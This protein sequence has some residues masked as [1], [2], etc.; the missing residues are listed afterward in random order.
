MGTEMEQTD[1]GQS[2]EPGSDTKSF[3]TKEELNAFREEILRETK[4]SLSKSFQAVQ[5]MTDKNANRLEQLIDEKVNGIVE[6]LRK[7]GKEPT[8]QEVQQIR[9]EAT[10][11]TLISQQQG[12]GGNAEPPKND[13]D[14]AGGDTA[15]EEDLVVQEAAQILKQYGLTIEDFE[16]GD[17]EYKMIEKAAET[18][19]IRAYF[20]AVEEA[21]K[22][23]AAKK[24]QQSTGRMP[25]LG[26]GEPSSNPIQDITDPSELWK[27]VK[28]SG[29]I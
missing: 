15:A 25:N 2:Q 9:N 12:A 1:A 19:S 23:K 13:I 20:N 11:E 4:E 26:G 6:T 14:G 8:P 5:S 18:G 16:E 24:K 7:Y 10:L 22:L 29:R 3:V 17:E 21:A 28:A 27:A